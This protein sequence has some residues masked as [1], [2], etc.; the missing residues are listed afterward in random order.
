M[1]DDQR[2]VRSDVVRVAVVDDDALVRAGVVAILATDQG[3]DVVAQGEDGR[4]ALDIV[5]R[6]RLDVVLLD[7]RMP[8]MDGLRALGE[9]KREHPDVPV[10]MLTTFADEAYIA[11]AVELGALGFLLKSDAPR[12]LTAAVKAISGGG[13]AFSPR[14][15]RWLVRSE[16]TERIRR[17]RSARDAMVVLSDR[18]RELL[19]ILGTGASNA[20]IARGMN[21]SDGTVKQYLRDIFDRL[22]V[23]NRVQAAILAHEAGLPA[24]GVAVRR[25]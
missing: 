20:E 14:V 1:I 11:E 4:A 15:A 6:H 2:E 25:P 7:I 9:L 3:L 22:G 13:A 5:R 24:G 23:V 18:Q 10:A 21:L 12:D 8:R 17:S 19:A 16:A